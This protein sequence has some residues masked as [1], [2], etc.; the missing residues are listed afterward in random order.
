VDVVGDSMQGGGTWKRAGDVLSSPSQDFARVGV[1]VRPKGNYQLRVEFTRVAGSGAASFYLPVG[2]RQVLF[3][4]DGWNGK[5]L[6]GLQ[7]VG[8]NDE[9]IPAKKEGF[10]MPPLKN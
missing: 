4:V 10:T 5:G 3:A 2:D 9:P 8:G 7:S 6:S 1:P